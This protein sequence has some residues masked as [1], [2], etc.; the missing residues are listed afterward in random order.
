VTRFQRLFGGPAGELE[1][2]VLALHP[3]EAA[4]LDNDS[5]FPENGRL[6]LEL[7]NKR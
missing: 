5:A 6:A 4:R 2:G 7:G 3:L 1:S